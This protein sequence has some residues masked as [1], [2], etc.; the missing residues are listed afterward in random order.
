MAVAAL[1]ALPLQAQA[2][3]VQTLVSNT[4]QDNS[5]VRPLDGID[6]AQAFGTGSNTA[7][8]DLDSI[9]LSLGLAATGTG[10]LTVTVREDASGDPSGTPLYTLTTP[11]PIAEDDLNAF[12]APAGATLDANTTYW[13]VASYSAADGPNWWRVLLSNG[14]DAGGASG[15]TID[16]PYKAD[17][18]TNPDG[19][20]V[21]SA[22][23]G[24]KLQ[25]K[26]TVK[27]V[28]TTVP[29][30][31]TSLTATANGSTQ[32]DLSWTAPA[33]NGGSTCSR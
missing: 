18:R 1:L 13:V 28:T 4:G 15:W 8:Y 11:D 2:Q 23:R 12:A 21:Q 31:P 14:I 29:D 22:S 5:G 33:D 17:S 16:S 19:W 32:I 26:G 20:E 25:V 10:T 24:M 7:G 9:V 27:G 30:A 3:T 6:F